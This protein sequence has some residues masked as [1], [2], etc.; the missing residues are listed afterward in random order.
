MHNFQAAFSPP[1]LPSSSRVVNQEMNSSLHH[2]HHTILSAT[3]PVSSSIATFANTSSSFPSVF[4]P[5]AVAVNLSS[6]QS[7]IVQTNFS[8]MST[9]NMNQLHNFTTAG[10]PT[11]AFASFPSSLSSND[12]SA[13]PAPAVSGPTASNDPFPSAASFLNFIEEGQKME[14]KFTSILLESAIKVNPIRCSAVLNPILYENKF[15]DE[16]RCDPMRTE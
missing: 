5:A 13:P 11:D 6:P 8:S 7:N 14:T 9:S 16:Q 3:F 4:N 15:R 2:H 12:F 10:I 1:C